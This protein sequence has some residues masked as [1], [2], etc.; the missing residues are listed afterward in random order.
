MVG[1]GQLNVQNSCDCE[2]K[3]NV[4]AELEAELIKLKKRPVASTKPSEQKFSEYNL[5]NWFH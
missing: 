4:I 1:C 2:L 5:L 3:E